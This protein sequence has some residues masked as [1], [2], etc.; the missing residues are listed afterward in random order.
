MVVRVWAPNHRRAEISLA[1]MLIPPTT[2]FLR[3]MVF[4]HPLSD[5]KSPYHFSPVRTMRDP[6]RMMSLVSI[7]R[8]RS[9][10][11]NRQ[12][13]RMMRVRVTCISIAEFSPVWDNGSGSHGSNL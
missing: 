10:K 8:A 5:E 6:R 7:Y 3:S 2:D 4:M 11:A 13:R 9:V 1:A 12:G